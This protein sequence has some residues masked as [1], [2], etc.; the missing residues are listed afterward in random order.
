VRSFSH[1]P[2]D[3]R[4][5]PAAIK[6][7]IIA[8]AA[9]FLLG[10]L[11]GDSFYQLFGLVPRRVLQDRW[12]WQL[13]TYLFIHGGFM[14]LLFNLFALWMFG[15]PV[16]SQWG[17]KEFIKY[18]LLCGLGAAAASI[19]LAPHSGVPIIGASGPVYGLL[20]A[21]AMLYPEAVV[22][23]YFFVPISAKHMAILFGLIEFF[24]GASG[25]T[26]GIARFA[27]LG[28]MVTGYL[29]IRWWW[30]LKIRVKALFRDIGIGGL[31]AAFAKKAKPRRDA[32][33]KPISPEQAMAEVDRILDKILVSGME[34][35][36]DEERAIM[37]RYGQHQRPQ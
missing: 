20:V 13:F 21:F 32:L 33:P 30:I 5:M 1:E 34:S 7:L 14:H 31:P 23:L 35:L 29:Y 2:I 12:L 37:K 27:H 36:T 15:M 16:D 11:V 26:P 22:Y 6:A 19:A 18:Y 8:N 9:M 24:A 17:G 10:Q 4:T 3:F 28:G 25:S